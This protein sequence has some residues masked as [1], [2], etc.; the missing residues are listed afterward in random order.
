M[1]I[2]PCSSP[3]TPSG[4]TLWSLL[5]VLGLLQGCSEGTPGDASTGTGSTAAAP[6]PAGEASRQSRDAIPPI[7]VIPSVLNWG[8][9]DPETTVDG[10]VELENIS[11]EPLTI[12][13]VQSSCACTTTRSLDGQT[14]PPGGTVTLEAQLDPQ[15][16][17]G[18]KTTRIKVLVEG[19]SKVLEFDGTAEVS[20]PVRIRPQY[21]NTVGE[22]NDP[23]SDAVV[24]QTGTLMVSS[25]DRQPFRVLSVQGRPPLYGASK[26]ATGG[27][28]V[29]HLLVYDIEDYRQPDGRYERYVV[30]E[31]DRE[32]A[33]LIEVLLRHRNSALD[34]DRRF[35]LKSYMLNLGRT[36]PGG[37]IEKVHSSREASLTGPIVSATTDEPGITVE[38]AS[39]EILESEDELATTYRFMVDPDKPEGMYYFPLTIRASNRADIVVPAFISVRSPAGASQVS[40]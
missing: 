3:S 4:A 13:T 25:L 31:T 18:R 9:T 22:P 34:I 28:R 2:P 16:S 27:P 19:Y 6:T 7:R 11:K 10:S 14:I 17:V 30:V 1:K 38:I 29:Q 40:E 8:T 21:I 15:N 23:D 39:Q 24:N 12:V 20:R 5:L 32:D 35:K 36:T 26:E 33:P 37:S